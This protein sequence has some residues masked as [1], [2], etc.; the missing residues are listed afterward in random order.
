[1]TNHIEITYLLTAIEK[2]EV[3]NENRATFLAR[4]YIAG[5]P[6]KIL[7]QKRKPN[8]ELMFRKNILL[9]YMFL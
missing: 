2:N 7:E 1:M 9:S 5:V 8:K 6:Y 4:A 3:R